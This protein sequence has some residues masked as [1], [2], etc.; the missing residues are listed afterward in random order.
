M[1][2]KNIILRKLQGN[3]DRISRKLKEFLRQN[4]RNFRE[5]L[6]KHWLMRCVMRHARLQKLQK[7]PTQDALLFISYS[8]TRHR[9]PFLSRGTN[10]IIL[11]ANFYNFIDP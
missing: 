10:A 3:F 6:W 5:P 7:V 11:W 4:Q 8:M 2:N 9:P 1:L